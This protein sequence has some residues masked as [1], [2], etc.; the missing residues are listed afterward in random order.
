MDKRQKDIIL[1]DVL[2]RMPYNVTVYGICAKEPVRL[3]SV[4]YD[5][6]YGNHLYLDE[7]GIKHHIVKPYLRPMSSMTEKELTELA[8]KVFQQPDIDIVRRWV[9]EN[10]LYPS[11]D[12][13]PAMVI[14][15]LNSH[16]FDYNG[17]IEIG[18]AM[19]APEDMYKVVGIADSQRRY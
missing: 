16:F 7:N 2:A 8:Y 6:T 17:L 19:E 14:D 3:V 1:K 9:F 12:G 10:K 13:N 5:K 4:K 11:I 18:L 15:W